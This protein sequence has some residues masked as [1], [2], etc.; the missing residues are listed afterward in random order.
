MKVVLFCGGL[1]TRMRE[2][3]ETIPKPL[4]AIGPHPII[5]HLM[6]YYAHFGHREFVLCLGYRGDLI[7]EYFA[8][9]QEA[10]ADWGVHFVETG[11]YATIAERLAAT[12]DH[13]RGDDMFLANYTDGLT[14]LALPSYLD[15]FGRSGAVAGF[16]AARVSQSYHFVSMDPAGQVTALTPA[17][18]ADVW[19]NGGFFAFRPAI[20]DY[21]DGADD[22]VGVPFHRLMHERRLYGYKHHGFWASMDTYKDKVR[23]DRR[24]DADDAP[25]EVWKR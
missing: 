16:V 1:G 9:H 4:A 2:H 17:D 10:F 14:N 22:L 8:Q 21:L 18:E 23:L 13:V 7:R 11:P 6:R 3:S 15:D 20:F 25:W 5:W 12:A 24:Y 19:I